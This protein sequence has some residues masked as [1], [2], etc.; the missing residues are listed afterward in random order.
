MISKSLMDLAYEL[1]L[2]SWAIVQPIAISPH[3]DAISFE[4][5]IIDAKISEVD[6]R[7]W[8]I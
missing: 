1:S 6:P 7:I 4:V 8:T 3:V 5:K 2:S